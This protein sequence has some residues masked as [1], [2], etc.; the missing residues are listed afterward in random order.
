MSLQSVS[1]RVFRAVS[2]PIRMQILLLLYHGGAMSYTEIMKSLRLSP[3]RDAGKFAYHLKRLLQAN[4]IKPDSGNGSYV[5][6]D[7]G[8]LVVN[9]AQGVGERASKRRRMRVRTSRLTI[10][11][12]DRNKIVDSLVREAGVPMEMACHIAKEAEE[13]LIVFRTK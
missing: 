2:S 11:E 6:T 12:F 3:D 10:E 8:R 4:L 1:M 5:I 9:M 7:L 13:R